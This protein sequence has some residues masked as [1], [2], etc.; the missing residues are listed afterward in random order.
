MLL[1]LV[2][3]RREKI[4]ERQL[5]RRE[6]GKGRQHT[7]IVESEDKD[8]ELLARLLHLADDGKERHGGGTIEAQ[9]TKKKK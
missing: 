6:G 2:T 4:K 1:S 9:V 5:E 7:R 8:T 3:R